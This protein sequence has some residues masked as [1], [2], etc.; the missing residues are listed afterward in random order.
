MKDRRRYKRHNLD[1]I[2][3]TGKMSLA[4][5]IKILDI[6]LGGV[7]IKADKRL[8]IGKEYIV[9]LQDKG[10]T[11]DVKGTVVRAE[12]SGTEKRSNGEMASIYTAGLV[13]KE[14][15]ADKIADFL[16][17]LEQTLIQQEAPPAA[18][19]PEVM[20]TIQ[21]V[22]QE[23][24]APEPAAA[25]VP[26]IA[27]PVQP[28]A[29]VEISKDP[30]VSN[31]RYHIR[32]NITTPQERILTYPLEFRVKQISLGGM[33]IETEQAVL[34]NSVIP[35]ELSLDDEKTVSF[36]GRI[37]SSARTE[38]EGKIRYALGVQFTNLTAKDT[39]LIKTFTDYL[40]E[41]GAESA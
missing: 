34:I 41:Q 32:F 21:P 29:Q 11:I 18:D 4:D 1:V 36:M 16:K 14:G 17:P 33:L 6:S 20:K 2:E 19:A 8:N 15:S 12:L 30:P 13:F 38:N 27:Q 40:A 39:Q 5:R 3:I 23:K 25:V 9:K 24:T 26:E 28:P 7:A 35:M 37:A 31:R 22:E 10:K